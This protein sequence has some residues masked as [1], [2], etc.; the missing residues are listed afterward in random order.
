[1]LIIQEH[2]LYRPYLMSTEKDGSLNEWI[3]GLNESVP[4]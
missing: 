1:M 4:I 2:P 3:D